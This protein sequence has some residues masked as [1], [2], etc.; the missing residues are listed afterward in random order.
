ML[1]MGKSAALLASI[2]L[3]SVPRSLVC[4]RSIELFGCSC[5]HQV[6]ELNDD[7]WPAAPGRQHHHYVVPDDDGTAG[8][9]LSFRSYFCTES[10]AQEK[11]KG[12]R[13]G[14]P[15]HVAAYAEERCAIWLDYRFANRLCS[16]YSRSTQ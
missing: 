10:F 6:T 16:C 11:G 8:T 3:G 12:L 1:L 15:Q 9:R 4:G 7:R 5:A 14:G 13:E 2:N